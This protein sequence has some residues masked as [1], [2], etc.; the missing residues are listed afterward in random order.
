MTNSFVPPGGPPQEP[1]PIPPAAASTPPTMAAGLSPYP[2]HARPGPPWHQPRPS[3]AM[4][5]WA[6]GMSLVPT[7][8]TMVLAVVFACVVLR[9]ARDGRE[10]GKGMAIAALC[11]VPA[12]IAV[13]VV[14]V[15]ISLAV[16]PASDDRDLAADNDSSSF[17]SPSP[18]SKMVRWAEL[19]PGDCFREP[20]MG[21]TFY[22][23]EKRP[24]SNRKASEVYAVFQQTGGDEYP[25]DAAVGKRADAGCLR[26][27]KRHL[28]RTPD[29][30]QYAY[31][32][33]HPVKD[34]WEDYGDRTTICYFIRTGTQG[35][36][37]DQE[38]A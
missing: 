19:E 5:G 35:P 6:L 4:A 28:E 17:D 37:A 24:C 36:P 20:R 22:F 10:H 23:L 29:A 31:G 25:G 2:A 11:I 38:T 26:R 1:T 15:V 13:G 30:P 32:Y 7:L 12:W 9:Q 16:A 27:Y 8:I 3:K 18:R 21:K 34:A 33:F 14:A